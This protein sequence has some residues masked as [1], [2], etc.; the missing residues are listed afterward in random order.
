LQ[1][2]ESAGPVYWVK[3]DGKRICFQCT[4]LN[5]KEAEKII[6]LATIHSLIP[7]PLRVA[8]LIATGIVLGESVGRA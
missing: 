4:G 2:V 1:A 7:E 6:K 5:I 8:H 3:L